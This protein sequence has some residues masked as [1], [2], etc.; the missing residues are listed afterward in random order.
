M[1]KAKKITKSELE[2]IRG[3]QQKTN[4]ILLEIGYLQVQQAK[5]IV[6]NEQVD[7]ELTD[8]KTK[9]QEKYGQIDIDLKDGSYKDIE[10]K[11]DEPVMKKA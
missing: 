4:S 2:S 6:A 1:A 9:L 5:L 3:I 10:E 11:K 7:K 8:V